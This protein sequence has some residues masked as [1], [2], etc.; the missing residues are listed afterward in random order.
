MTI[1][2]IMK[3][4][5][6]SVFAIVLFLYQIPFF[7]KVLAQTDTETPIICGCPSEINKIYQ[8]RGTG[9]TCV[10]DFAT[11]KEDP[12]VNHL[13]VEDAEITAQ[14][15]ADDRARQFIYWVVTNGSIDNHPVLFKIWSTVRNVSYFFVILV[16]AVMGLGMIIS[17]RSNFNANIKVWPSVMKILAILLFITFSASLVI[18]IIQLSDILM[19]FFIENLGG[20]DLFNIYF[21]SISQEKNYLDFV[22][23]RDLNIRVQEAYKA[24]MML[25]KL[26]N[27]SYYVMGGM[28]ILRKVLL[29]FLLF[30]SP[31]L[32]LLMPFVFIRNIGW[33]WIGVFFQWVF[34]GP[35]FALFLG[36][37]ASIWKA[38]IPFVF[39]FSRVGTTQGYIFPTAINILYGGPAQRLAI[40]NNGN[41]V[42]TFTEYIITL[43]MLWAVT[44]FPWWLLRIFRDYCC[45]GIIAMK[46]ILMSMYDQQ[47]GSPP[48]PPGPTPTPTTIGTSLNIPREVEI[49]IKVRLETAEEIKKAKTEEISRSLN[50]TATKLTDIAHFETNKQVNQT[51][52][53]NLNFLQNPIQAATTTDRQK[54][55]TLRTELYNRALKN[56]QLAKGILSSISTSRI[57]QTERRQE[58]LR[59]IPQMVPVTHVVSMK[60]KMPQEN[61]KLVTASLAGNNSV[62]A[63]VAQKTQL[64]AAQIKTVLTSLHKNIDESPAQVTQKVAEQSGVKKEEV[65]K[66][67]ENLPAS[68]KENKEVVQTVVDSVTQP[69]KNIEKTVSI[70]PSISLEDYEQVKKMWKQQYEKGEVPVAENIKTREQWVEQ[71]IVFITNTLNKLLSPNDELRQQGLDDIGYILPIFLINNLKGEEL[72]VYLKAKLEAAKAVEEE[73][74]KEKEIEERLKAK[75]E[76]EF[77]EVAKPK[78]QEKAQEMKM[79]EKMEIPEEKKVEEN[80]PEDQMTNDKS[81]PKS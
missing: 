49:P 23:C 5:L 30:V 64:Q 57:E 65:V 14:G 22:G 18:T 2:K 45:E 11:F 60:V 40:L 61:V 81:N 67:I 3:K 50:M 69:E 63:A 39:D 10:T 56:D 43:I 47:R 36:A 27:V 25:L 13:W 1:M 26:T 52:Q 74:Q 54:Y 15:K 12:T 53:K 71:D 78:E 31:F 75:T 32:P 9:E 70:P 17:Q 28:L 58:I 29:W 44:F 16:A 62:V 33:I 55:M 72:I 80:K 48:T 37:L 7:G 51:V 34:Y 21:A 35:L 20:K 68:V 66:I 38:G 41:Y 77:V 76:E 73:K 24:E 8:D 59:S 79:E 46:N 6:L 19:K 4:I 42:D